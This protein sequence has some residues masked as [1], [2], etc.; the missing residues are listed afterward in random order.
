[1]N[2]FKGRTYL[3]KIFVIG[4]KSLAKYLGTNPEIYGRTGTPILP[5][6]ALTY[7]I[8]LPH[9]KFWC[10]HFIYVRIC[11]IRLCTS[12]IRITMTC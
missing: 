9:M 3:T 4:N 5:G 10:H 1:M 11:P 8:L 2:F 7:M 6:S 12:H